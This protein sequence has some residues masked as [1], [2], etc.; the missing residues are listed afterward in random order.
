METTYGVTGMTCEN[1][2]RH[3]REEVSLIQGVTSA[4]ADAATGLLVVES[5]SPLDE[6][7]VRTA[8]EEAGYTLTHV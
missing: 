4:R 7:S 2:E 6:D 8:V 1:C 5:D 3:V